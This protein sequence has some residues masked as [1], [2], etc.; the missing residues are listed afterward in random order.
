MFLGF[1]RLNIWWAGLN[2]ESV[3]KYDLKRC[4]DEIRKLL[5]NIKDEVAWA[6]FEDQSNNFINTNANNNMSG[7]IFILL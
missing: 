4:I 3:S 6:I 5:G 7:F 1:T 2:Q